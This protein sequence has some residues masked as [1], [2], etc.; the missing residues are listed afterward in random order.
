M[1]APVAA[2]RAPNDQT[3]SGI[4][5]TTVSPQSGAVNTAPDGGDLIASPIQRTRSGHIGVGVDAHKH[6]RVAAV[7]DTIVGIQAT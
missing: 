5:G 4:V 7:M 3:K 6:I 1:T 2:C